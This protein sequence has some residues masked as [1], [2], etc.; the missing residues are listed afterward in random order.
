M[1]DVFTGGTPGLSYRDLDSGESLELQVHDMTLGMPAWGCLATNRDGSKLAVVN[2]T[3]ALLWEINP[4]AWRAQ[5]CRIAGRN[6]DLR[7]W[8]EAF[9]TDEPYRCSCPEYP[10]GEGAPHDAEGCRERQP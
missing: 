2:G 4:S 9:G 7:E 1:A 6:A 3:S 10:A 5:A 8:T